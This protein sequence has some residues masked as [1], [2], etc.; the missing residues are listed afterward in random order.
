M[1][2]FEGFEGEIF[3]RPS[4]HA[5]LKGTESGATVTTKMEFFDQVTICLGILEMQTNALVAE[6]RDLYGE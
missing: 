3:F 2:L 1:V 6:A 5:N 4:P